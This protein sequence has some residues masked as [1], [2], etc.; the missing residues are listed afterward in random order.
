MGKLMGKLKVLIVDDEH[1]IRNLLRM[2]IDWEAQGMEIV[3]E[4]ANAG[5]AMALVE[6]LHP[7]IIFTDIY[8]PKVD[9]IEFS[10]QVLAS[11]PQIK[12][13]IVTGHD[14]F[15]YAR[16]SIKIGVF[17][18]ILKPIR[19]AELVQITS[20]LR[21]KIQKERLHKHKIE[22]LQ[23][24]MERNQNFLKEQFLTHWLRGAL[25][26]QEIVDKAIH[27]GLPLCGEATSVQIALI[28]PASTLLIP[29]ED[30]QKEKQE[31]QLSK[32]IATCKHEVERF[33][34]LGGASDRNCQLIIMIDPSDRLVLIS[35]NKEINLVKDCER[36][37]QLL[38]KS[39]HHVMNIGVGSKYIKSTDAYLSYQEAA[40]ALHY[41]AFIGE[42]H[43]ICFED[44][45]DK[46]DTSYQSDS[47]MLDQL[48]FHISIGASEQAVEQLNA[49]FDISFSSITQFR[50]A[51]IDVIMEC[52]RAAIEQQLDSEVAFDKQILASILS[53]NQLSELLTAL[54][55]Y[56]TDVANTIYAKLQPPEDNLIYQVKTYLE[57]HLSD[58]DLSLASTAAHFYIS[59]G[60]L[61]RLM[62]KE[63]GQT[64]VEYLTQIRMK[65]AELLLKQTDLKGYEIGEQVGIPDPH[66]FSVLFKK[67]IGRSM[68]EYRSVRN[69]K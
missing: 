44:I 42:N 47:K 52:Q 6:Q 39:H 37:G 1:L 56:V 15:E 46:M 58:P 51:A 30:N 59:S 24:V 10:E 2:R 28:E 31:K 53:A 61:G 12:I 64:F 63:T 11:Y 62:K 18:F 49:I 27:F 29:Q 65:K 20:K 19:P 8:M 21:E 36:I 9:G 45:A 35:C 3:G 25:T 5:E 38:S 57:Q 26:E 7:D 50:M 41:H 69:F 34:D 67:S 55:S 40:R 43:V 48:Q 23:E 14:E 13:V 68:N 32:L 22:Q 17:D 4:A 66:Y 54:K 16:R 60:H 33:Y